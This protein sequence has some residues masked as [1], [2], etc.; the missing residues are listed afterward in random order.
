VGVALLIY[1]CKELKAKGSQGHR[2]LA[3]V[4]QMSKGGGEASKALEMSDI[5]IKIHF[6]SPCKLEKLKK[7]GRNNPTT[8][9]TT[10]KFSTIPIA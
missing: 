6:P 7:M 4:N 5:T 8:S 2:G 9:T 10:T 1:N 3:S